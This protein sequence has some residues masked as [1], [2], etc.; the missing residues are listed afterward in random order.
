MTEKNQYNIATNG[1]T[2]QNARLIP[3]TVVLVPPEPF[4]KIESESRRSENHVEF[5]QL[6]SSEFGPWSDHH[7]NIQQFI[8]ND[9]DSMMYVQSGAKRLN[10]FWL[11][12]QGSLPAAVPNAIVTR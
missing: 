2:M 3:R 1:T 10:A 12:G 7:S 5:Y 9:P 6:S 11:P 4:T 8:Y